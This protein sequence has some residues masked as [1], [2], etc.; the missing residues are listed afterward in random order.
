MVSVSILDVCIVLY[1][2]L[3]YYVN[4][5]QHLIIG[6]GISA[7]TCSGT[8]SMKTIG[9]GCVL[10][11]SVYF[12]QFPMLNRTYYCLQPSIVAGQQW[13]Y[14]P[15]CHYA[16]SVAQ[17]SCWCVKDHWQ[18]EVSERWPKYQIVTDKEIIISKDNNFVTNLF[19]LLLNR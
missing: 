10:F 18:T 13:W 12:Q 14:F 7:R 15:F 8:M 16:C 2:F 1:C 3:F 11:Q 5:C 9:I 6:N 17:V 4:G 19:I